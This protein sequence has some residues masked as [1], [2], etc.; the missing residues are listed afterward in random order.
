MFKKI[1]RKIL[2]KINSKGEASSDEKVSAQSISATGEETEVCAIT[3]GGRREASE[4]ED[5]QLKEDKMSIIDPSLESFFVQY[6]GTGA[7]DVG[8]L[9]G[10]KS[11]EVN[12]VFKRVKEEL[13]RSKDALVTDLNVALWLTLQEQV[14]SSEPQLVIL[15]D[16]NCQER[17][18]VGV[19]L[20]ERGEACS[21]AD[22]DDSDV[23]SF[24]ARKILL[25]VDS[26]ENC[27]NFLRSAVGRAT[28][29]ATIVIKSESETIKDLIQSNKVRAQKARIVAKESPQTAGFYHSNL[30]VAREIEHEVV[31][32]VTDTVSKGCYLVDFFAKYEDTAIIFASHASDADFVEKY[33]SKGRIA[34]VKVIGSTNPHFISRLNSDIDRGLVKVVIT[35]DIGARNISITRFPLVI[36]YGLPRD[37]DLYRERTLHASRI[38]NVINSLDIATL[39]TIVE[40][41]GINFVPTSFVVE[42]DLS[43]E[44]QVLNYVPELPKNHFSYNRTRALAEHIL[45]LSSERRLA[46]VS[47]LL[48]ERDNL[49]FSRAS[50]WFGN[51]AL[52]NRNGLAPTGVA[53]D[54]RVLDV[55]VVQEEIVVRYCAER[56]DKQKLHE[57]E[58]EVLCDSLS[59]SRE[60]LSIRD[61]YLFFDIKKEQKADADEDSN[62][63]ERVA[64]SLNEGQTKLDNGWLVTRVMEVSIPLGA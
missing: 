2:G 59:L 55:E 50:S 39:E 40:K 22:I 9:L 11:E 23:E 1:S 60:S 19:T 61:N 42:P 8:L 32:V 36:N 51:N 47:S 26:S 54:E 46:V 14:T 5:L 20:G 30:L 43:E 63:E 34:C 37:C 10:L 45:S 52:M 58:I 4:G 7:G 57:K 16:D 13:N 56:L 6:L 31:Q 29:I 28:A 44:I 25:I 38:L 49:A 18:K 41:F 53:G 27:H 24:K 64:S 17:M 3:H 33:L 48:Q 62:N 12:V 21:L 35:T 15:V